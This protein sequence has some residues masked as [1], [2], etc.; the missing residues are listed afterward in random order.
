M[1]GFYHIKSITASSEII[2]QYNQKKKKEKKKKNIELKLF[3][4]KTLLIKPFLRRLQIAQNQQ[5]IGNTHKK[6]VIQNYDT[7]Y[8][9]LINEWNMSLHRNNKCQYSVNI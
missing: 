5:K 7:N 2:H 6:I 1:A 8:N 4:T 3:I 9:M